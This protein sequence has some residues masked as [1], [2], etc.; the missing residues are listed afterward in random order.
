MAHRRGQTQAQTA[1]PAAVVLFGIDEHGKA[2]AA[3]FGTT[4]AKLAT[5]AADQLRLKVVTIANPALAE[6]AAQLPAGRIHARGRGVVPH[7]RADLYAKLVSAAS[8]N[9]ATNEPPAQTPAQAPPTGTPPSDNGG[10]RRP[11]NWDEI[12]AGHLVLAHE[13]QEEG[14][15]D[16]IIVERTGDMCTLKWRDYP[17]ERRF[18]RHCR[19]LALLC[20]N[21]AEVSVP[22]SEKPAKASGAKGAAAKPPSSA[23]SLPGTWAEIDVGS[24]VLAQQDGPWAGWW[25]AIP[26]ENKGDTLTLGWRD[27]AKLPV[28]N[29]AR[30]SLALLCPS[31]S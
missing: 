20:P 25:E 4:E 24:L 19:A 13:G 1:P 21:P 8:A 5:K 23:Q 2:K 29:R 6:I 11:R 14:W 17:R 9:G 10:S 26:T 16:A 7:V 15:Y 22:A 28:I 18:T 30:T 12:A 3:R 31:A 27:Y